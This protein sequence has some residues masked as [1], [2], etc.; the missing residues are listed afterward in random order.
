VLNI[1]T[2][3]YAVIIAGLA[4][5]GRLIAAAAGTHDWLADTGKAVT[6]AMGT[7][8]FLL[9]TG[10]VRDYFGALIAEAGGSAGRGEEVK[11]RNL[12]QL[13]MSGAWLLYSGAMMA[14]GILRRAKAVRILSMVIF[15]IAI[16]K[17][18]GYDLSFLQTLY[19]NN[20]NHPHPNNHHPHTKPTH[21]TTDHHYAPQH[22]PPRAG[23][24]SA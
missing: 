20:T 16:V 15:A 12:Q 24:T 10:E 9:L 4:I 19:T 1:R 7:A 14:A 11:L 2:G 22:T 8:G 23:R 18:F 3:A 5:H 13:W 6:L 21:K 17:I